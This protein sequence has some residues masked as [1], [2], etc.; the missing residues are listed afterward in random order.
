MCF[1][2]T[3][4]AHGVCDSTLRA[5]PP[6]FVRVIDEAVT[7]SGAARDD[8][9]FL[10]ITHMKPSFHRE[11]LRALGLR[12]DQSIYLEE[13]GHI[14]SVDQALALKLA[15]E[16]GLLHDGDLVVLAGAGTGYTWSATAVRWGE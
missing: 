12:E 8:L 6:G 3:S 11:L 5:G 16:R 15:Q 13:Y 7:G 2:A 9:K 1:I 4:D 14:Q 10:A